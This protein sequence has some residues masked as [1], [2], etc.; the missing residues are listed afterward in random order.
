MIITVE[1]V[2]SSSVVE[3]LQLKTCRVLKLG[4]FVVAV[5][6]VG[7]SSIDGARLIFIGLL[8][9]IKVGLSE[10]SC[11][12]LLDTDLTDIVSLG[13]GTVVHLIL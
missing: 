11:N 6:S 2:F 9:Q 7:H 3:L 5:R 10:G 12:F 4:C 8:G 1:R 13:G